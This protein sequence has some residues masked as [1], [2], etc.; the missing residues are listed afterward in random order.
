MNQIDFDEIENKK[1]FQLVPES[2]SYH[3]IPGDKLGFPAKRKNRFAKIS[4]FSQTF[5]FAT[6]WL[7]FCISFAREKCKKNSLFSRNFAS[8]CFVKKCEILRKS[9]RSAN[10][11]FRIFLRNVSFAA[12]LRTNFMC[13]VS[14][15]WKACSLYSRLPLLNLRANAHGHHGLTKR[16]QLDRKL[17]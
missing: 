4:Y 2:F 13:G 14:L 1:T 15:F 8:I 12:N 3:S 5:F 6:I 11:I 17:F 16:N 7:R 10:E 9:L